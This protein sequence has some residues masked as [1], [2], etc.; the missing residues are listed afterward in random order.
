MQC[1]RNSPDG[2]FVIILVSHHCHPQEVLTGV[3]RKRIFTFAEWKSIPHV[4]IFVRTSK[5]YGHETQ[6][7]KI[8]ID[9]ASV[10]VNQSMRGNYAQAMWMLFLCVA[11]CKLNERCCSGRSVFPLIRTF[12]VIATCVWSEMI[13]YLLVSCNKQ[14]FSS[15]PCAQLF[16]RLNT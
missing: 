13:I 10:A 8:I 5:G 9:D 11:F 3:N 1:D 6:H 14:L 12:V 2:D 16:F 15:L 7:R 4:C